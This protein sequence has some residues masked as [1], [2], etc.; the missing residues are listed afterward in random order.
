M[1]KHWKL[2]DLMCVT[3]VQPQTSRPTPVSFC[4]ICTK[5]TQKLK[6]ATWKW[7][8]MK[9]VKFRCAKTEER[10][11]KKTKHMVLIRQLGALPVLVAWLLGCGTSRTEPDFNLDFVHTEQRQRPRQPPMLPNRIVWKNFK[12]NHF[13]GRSDE[14]AS[15]FAHSR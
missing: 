14:C 7:G 10:E 15:Q 13:V 9:C 2:V 5:C 4:Y 1:E 6:S 11:K 3:N 8:K 12:Q